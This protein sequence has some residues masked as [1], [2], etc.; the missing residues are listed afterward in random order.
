ME[1]EL[2]VYLNGRLVPKSEAKISVYD[3]GLLYGDGV[4]EGIRAYSGNVFL[5][6]EHIDRLYESA[7]FIELKIPLPKSELTAALLDT[8]RKNGLKDAYIRLVV[9][10][11]AGDLGVNPAL[12]KEA[13]VF[14]I[15]EPVVVSARADP[16]E[17]SAAI[18]SVRR[19]SVDATTHECKS[20]NYLNSILAVLEANRLGVD[21]A[22]MLDTRGFVSE[23]P[24]M[25]LFIVKKRVMYT[26]GTSSGILHGI[27]RER[28][29]RLARNLGI[30]VVEK[31]ITAFELVVA[32]EAFLTGTLSELVGLTSVNKRTIGDGTAGPITRKLYKEFNLLARSGEEGTPIYETEKV[33]A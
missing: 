20:L 15:T 11:G 30:T 33:R 31:D 18:T 5:L 4:F 27:T 14:I 19:D 32:D 23:G 17:F 26:P 28:V 21:V 6:K 7:D 29:I 13:A 10:R 25:N 1:K 9:T 22:V 24:T 8:L 3:H 12:C 2:L 16:K